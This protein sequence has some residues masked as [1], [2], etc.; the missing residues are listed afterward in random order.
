L[1]VYLVSFDFVEELETK[2]TAF[3]QKK[4]LQSE[5]RLLDETDYNSFIDK[6]NE[7]W[8][9]A[10]PATLFVDN[11]NGRKEFYEGQFEQGELNAR[12]NNFID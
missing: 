8:S 9:G 12:F 5:I 6:V 3:V 11:R 10:I 7:D 2:V 4:D 1:T